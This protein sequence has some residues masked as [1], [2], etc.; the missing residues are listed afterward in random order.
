LSADQYPKSNLLL[1]LFL[2]LFRRYFD[3]FGAIFAVRAPL[4]P[5]G[6]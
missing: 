4:H 5:F 3:F 6:A 2:A 1:Q